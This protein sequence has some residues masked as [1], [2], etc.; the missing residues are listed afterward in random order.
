M[1]DWAN[2]KHFLKI[3]TFTSCFCKFQ[4][5]LL[6]VLARAGR[7]P[8]ISNSAS[9]SSHKRGDHY[10]G[11]TAPPRRVWQP[12]QGLKSPKQATDFTL[13]PKWIGSW[14][15]LGAT[16]STGWRRGNFLR[17]CAGWNSAN[18]THVTQL[19]PFH[20]SNFSWVSL[21]DRRIEQRK[22]VQGESSRNFETH[23]CL[24]NYERILWEIQR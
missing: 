11:S 13:Q 4:C 7:H 18:P 10:G 19:N 2:C 16:S 20:Q 9:A 17:W 8:K 23:A 3:G 1:C 22:I 24:P 12:L 15:K 5:E 14:P 21:E 6:D